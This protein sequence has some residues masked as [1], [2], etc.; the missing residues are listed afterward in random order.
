MIKSPVKASSPINASIQGLQQV[1]VSLG[2]GVGG[3]KLFLVFEFSPYQLP[4]I[5]YTRGF[6]WLSYTT[7]AGFK[8]TI[9]V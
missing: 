1:L 5:V 9:G 3:A 2:T 7:V 4:C 6:W 8:S